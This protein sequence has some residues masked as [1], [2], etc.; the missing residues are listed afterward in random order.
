MFRC[1]MYD[2]R[3]T[4]YDLGFGILTG[5][6]SSFSVGNAH[7]TGTYNIGENRISNIEQGIMNVEGL[8]RELSRTIRELRNSKFLVLRFDILFSLKKRISNI[9]QGIMNVEGLS[10]VSSV[11]R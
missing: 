6:Q 8:R 10:V 11:E 2:L 5:D 3:F 4:M 1:T 9:E 7:A